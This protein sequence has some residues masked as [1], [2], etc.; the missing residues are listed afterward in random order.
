MQNLIQERGCTSTAAR[1]IFLDEV[2]EDI[3]RFK[4][5]AADWVTESDIVD[6]V[7]SANSVRSA[8]RGQL[9]SDDPIR[10]YINEIGLLRALGLLED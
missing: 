10:A 3:S 4:D 7:I 6:Y 5:L 2:E 1:D 8:V 9:S